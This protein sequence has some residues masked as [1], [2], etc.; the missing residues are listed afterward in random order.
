MNLN[1]GVIPQA[2]CYDEQ[3]TVSVVHTQKDVD[4]ML[5]VFAEIAR[6]MA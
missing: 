2:Q 3:W 1:R 4:H 6:E 5:Q